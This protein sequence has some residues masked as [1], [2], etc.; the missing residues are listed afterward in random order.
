MLLSCVPQNAGLS[1]TFL[2]LQHPWCSWLRHRATSRKVSGSIPDGVFGVF[3]WHI[4]SGRTMALGL[5]QPLTEM[6]TT[7]ISCMVKAADVYGWQPYHLHVPIVLKSGS[8][9]LQ[10]PSGPVQACNGIVLQHP[11]YRLE[12]TCIFY[13]PHFNIVTKTLFLNT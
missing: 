1:F 5:T 4:P 13:S 6:S 10:E 3:H 2:S 8:L 12:N 7:N 9:I 11:K